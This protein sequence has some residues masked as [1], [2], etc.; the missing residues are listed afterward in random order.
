MVLRRWHRWLLLTVVLMVIAPSAFADLETADVLNLF[1]DALND[2]ATEWTLVMAGIGRGWAFWVFR[3]LMLLQLSLY[4]LHWFIYGKGNAIESFLDFAARYFYLGLLWAVV[5]WWGGLGGIPQ[6]FFGLTG[7]LLTGLEGVD[8]LET[9]D[10][11]VGTVFGVF[12]DPSLVVPFI[13][14]GAGWVLITLI[15][16]LASYLVIV[17]RQIQIMTKSLALYSTGPLFMS[18]GAFTLTAPLADGWI[19]A[20]VKV[21]LEIMGLYM[22]VHLGAEVVHSFLEA[23][24]A[25]SVLDIFKQLVHLIRFAIATAVWAIVVAT[26]PA[27]MASIAEGY[28]FGM[29]DMVRI[30]R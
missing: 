12:L 28:T 15:I 3:T 14:G 2:A 21:G 30:R 18:F 16:V 19:R 26:L 17:L 9:A 25:L 4:F 7:Q 27:T 22:A 13:A 10:S 23:W 29:A 6:Q 20:T 24:Q 5:N 11:A 8:P 1:I